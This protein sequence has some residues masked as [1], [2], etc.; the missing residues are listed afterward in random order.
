MSNRRGRC[1]GAVRR[2]AGRWQ[3]P[4]RD[5]PLV[6]SVQP[7]KWLEQLVR[8]AHVESDALVTDHD[9][10]VAA[11]TPA[12]DLDADR[13]APARELPRVAH[14]LA[15]HQLEQALVAPRVQAGLHADVGAA[16]RLGVLQLGADPV[17]EQAQV[18]VRR[19]EFG[20]RDVGRVVQRA[21]QPAHARRRGADAAEVVA[22]GVVQPLRCAIGQQCRE[23][24][25]RTQRRA[26][27]VRDRVGEQLQ[28]VVGGEARGVFGFGTRLEREFGR[29]LRA[30][31]AHLHQQVRRVTFAVA[32]HRHVDVRPDGVAVA[33]HV[34]LLRV[35]R[36][37]VAVDQAAQERLAHRH[38]VR[39]RERGGRCADDVACVVA[40][41]ALEGGVHFKPA[42]VQVDHR[43]A[44]AGSVHRET[45]TVDTRVLTRDF[46]HRWRG[47]SLSCRG[48][49]VA[50]P[51]VTVRCR[52]PARRSRHLAHNGS[53]R[54]NRSCSSSSS[55]VRCT[56]S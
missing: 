15:Q 30:D 4:D 55:P 29:V 5:H 1:R 13:L 25:D 43:H 40:E 49:S 46:A 38:V 35:E 56:S 28:L 33:M 19:L 42:A 24:F 14:Q 47:S 32:H 18:H 10:E 37:D 36:G 52:L 54:C 16:L 48:A 23:A 26:Q 6:R 20:T 34:A 27:V 21:E 3:G 2:C 9:L 8:I 39:M 45:E 31:V 41:D 17:G 53:W 11:F 22:V 44:D 7:L 51:I 50:G 12:A